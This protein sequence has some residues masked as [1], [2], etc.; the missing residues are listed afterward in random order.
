[1]DED[2]KIRGYV[3]AHNMDYKGNSKYNPLTGENR[4]GIEAV[5]PQELNDRF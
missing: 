3:R 5:V 4:L 2:T 1:M